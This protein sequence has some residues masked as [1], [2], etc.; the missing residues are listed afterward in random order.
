M[1]KFV[2]C[3]L[4]ASTILLSC[5][6]VD[7]KN[8]PPPPPDYL[9]GL[10]SRQITLNG[11]SERPK[12]SPDGKKIIFQSLRPSSHKGWQI[13]E[14]DMIS[15]KE[16]RITFSDGDA[17]DAFYKDNEEIFYASTTDEI[18][19]NPLRDPKKDAVFPPSDIYSSDLFGT[20]IERLID[21]SGYDGVPIY[22]ESFGKP[23]LLFISHR[24]DVSGIYQLDLQKLRLQLIL[25]DK[26]KDKKYLTISPT[27]DK[28]AWI[29]TDLNNHQQSLVVYT[30]KNKALKVLKTDNGLIRDLT[31]AAKTPERLFYS[32]QR[33]TEKVFRIESYDL[34][35]KC[36]Q[37]VLQ[38]P[39]TLLSPSLSNDRTERLAFVREVEDKKQIFT[40]QLIS[41]LGPCLEAPAQANLK[42]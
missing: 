17:F 10:D 34:E 36:T 13:Y 22:Y 11:I 28:V 5:S 41:D 21:N 9:N 7:K 32:I 35:K 14:L 33:P 42:Q 3:F 16:R 19:E 18:K 29:E 30:F 4:T 23:Q 1:K 27:K 38:G 40:V 15:N 37:V 6:H 24:D 20:N 31:F 2:S 39:E 26:G 8:E 25:A 12:F